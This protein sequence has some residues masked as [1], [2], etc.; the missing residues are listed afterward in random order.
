MISKNS[1]L[2]K[3]AGILVFLMILLQGTYGIFAYL[4]PI[5][6]SNVRGTELYTAMDADWIVIYGSRTLFITFILGYLLYVRNYL[7]LM[8]CALF[9]LVMPVTDGILAYEAEAQFK[10]VVKH[11]ATVLYLLVTYFV[12]KKVYRLESL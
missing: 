6:F 9:G 3:V 12:L 5:A 1:R 4:D 10:V 8:W 7:I 11:V 2:E